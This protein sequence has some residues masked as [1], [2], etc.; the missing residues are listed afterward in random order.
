MTERSER[1]RLML[2]TETYWPEIGGGERQSRCLASGLAALGREVTILTRRSRPGLPHREMDG[3]AAV[4]RLPPAG[5]GR[6]RKWLTLI[7]ACLA[8]C[9][10]RRQYDAVLVSGFRILGIAALAARAITGRPT[11]LKADSRGELSGDYFRAGLADAGLTPESAGVSLALRVRN[12]LLRRADAFVAISD[13]LA[14]EFL[15]NG[16]PPSRIRRIPNG[17]DTDVFRPAS[18]EERS[19]LRRKLGLP[20][21]PVAVY[22]GRLVSYKG[23][24]SLLRAWR[25]VPSACL[26]LVGEGGGDL[27]A[28]EQ[29]LRE[30]VAAEGLQARVR[31]AG[32]VERVD[33]WL[34]AADLYVFPTEDEAFGLALVEA[35]ACGLPCVTTRIG[36]L[37]DFVVDEVNAVAVPTRDEVALAAAC[38]SLLA[39]EGRRATLGAAARRT[40]VERFGLA[41]VVGAYASLL[42]EL[43]AATRAAA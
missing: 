16:V 21:A 43:A 17:V 10:R 33:D 37:R 1:P 5:R 41:A 13:E 4:L 2:A 30:F 31:F 42:D 20:S 14:S 23:L 9:I 6:W 15:E 8:L 18:A 7:P 32:P 28:C 22:T 11:I 19:V 36:G 38:G 29:E 12:V 34:R 35:M 27:H 24:P 3:A 40:A 26:V 39:S 25:N